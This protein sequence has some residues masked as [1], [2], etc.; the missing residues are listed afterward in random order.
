MQDITQLPDGKIAV[1][2]AN[3]IRLI[4]TT[5]D[6]VGELDYSVAN[7]DDINKYIHT[8]Y[9]NDNNELWI[10]TDGGGVYVYE[11]KK[12]TCRQLTTAN[13]LPSNTVCSIDKDC[14]GGVPCLFGLDQNHG[15]TYTQG[16]TLFPQNI[17]VAATFNRDIARRSAEATAYETRAVSVPWT[18]SPTLDLARDARWSRFYEN[19]GE[20]CYVNAEMGVAQTLGF[21]GEDPNHVDQQHVAVSLKHYMGYSVPWS[22]KDRTPAYIAPAQLRE[23]FFAP[24]LACVKAGAHS[25]MVNSAS[26]NGMPVH[27]NRELLTVWLKEQTGWDGVCSSPTGPT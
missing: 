18:F 12:K 26:V 16:G 15:S 4:D 25:I 19:F 7:P 20:D 27:A 9:V 2:T 5:T 8:L 11:L 10:G 3:G 23:K 6:E 1:G 13:G 17:N 14:K 22:G 24:F 21:Q